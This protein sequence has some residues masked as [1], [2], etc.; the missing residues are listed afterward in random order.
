MTD[1]LVFAPQEEEDE[2]DEKTKK[3]EEKEEVAFAVGV[4]NIPYQTITV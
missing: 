4:P 2:T 1:L 3:A